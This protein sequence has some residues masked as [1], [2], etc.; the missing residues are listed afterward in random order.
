MIV[1]RSPSFQLL[2][3][4]LFSTER[5]TELQLLFMNKFELVIET[6]PE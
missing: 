3:L 6:N 2:L 5:Q 1:K 4:F